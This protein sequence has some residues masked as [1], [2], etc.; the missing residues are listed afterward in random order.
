MAWRKRVA[1]SSLTSPL[2]W[3]AGAGYRHAGA[4]S[5]SATRCAHRAGP[6]MRGSCGVRGPEAERLGRRSWVP[7]HFLPAA[8]SA[9]SAR[10]RSRLPPL[11]SS[12][13]AMGRW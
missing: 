8:A 13:T 1:A 5:R 6:V 12:L 11:L 9:A 10:R 3:R 2:G 4:V 7:H